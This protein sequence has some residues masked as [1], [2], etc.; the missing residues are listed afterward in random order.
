MIEKVYH[1]TAA[2]ILAVLQQRVEI[3]D[4]AICNPKDYFSIIHR[5]QSSILGIVAHHNLTH[6]AKDSTT[7]GHVFDTLSSSLSPNSKFIFG[8]DEHDDDELDALT[9]FHTWFQSAAFQQH[10]SLSDLYEQ[11]LVLEFPMVGSE[12]AVDA[13]GLNAIGSF[14]TPT[15]LADETVKL[16]LDHYIF[17]NTGIE[18]FSSA[19]KSKQQLQHVAKLLLGSTFADYSCGTGSFLLAILRYCQTHVALSQQKLQRIALKFYA[20]E[21][22]SLSLEIAKFQVLEAIG[23]FNLYTKLSKKFI[24]GNPLIA[25]SNQ[26]PDIDFCHEFYYYNGLAL[27]PKQIPACDV[28][29]GNPPWGTVGFDLSFYFHLLCPKLNDKEG[30][31]QLV[32]ALED[33]E[34]NHPD[35]YDWLL[36]H[37]AAIDFASEEIYND[38]RFEHSS[39]GGLQ[40]NAL[41]TEL[42]DGSCTEKGVVG[43]ILN[44]TTL[45]A[46]I[47]K[48]LVNYLAS[49]KRI[50]ARFD[51]LNTNKLFNV[52]E[53]EEFSILILGANGSEGF[54][55]KTG[56][57]QL[58]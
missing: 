33:V 37:D 20:I 6:W 4:S 24:H 44:G 42:C 43:L 14:Y 49:Q 48:R 29:V 39:M 13:E 45:S 47:N 55:H 40:T 11:L 26:Y 57:T 46:P 34:E 56:I 27:A 16:T 31:D 17:K 54:V 22:D 15:H 35:L 25:P 5:M 28:I 52:D 30:E 12:I 19:D 10:I 53:K 23:G 51:F 7:L 21:V 32:A 41:F 1:K 3:R 50:Q 9:G 2:A 58:F 38:P 18:S 8:F 36:Q